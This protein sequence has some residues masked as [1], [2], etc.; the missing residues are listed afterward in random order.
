MRIPVVSRDNQPLMP[1]TPARVRRW[2]A[3]G[4]AIKKWSDLGAVDGLALACSE[5][6]NY[7]SFHIANTRG[8]AW[9]GS[10]QLTPA[11]FRVIRRPPIS[12]RQLHLM[13]PSIGGVRRKYGGTTTRHGVR[14]GDVVKAEMAG[15]VSVG[16]VSGDTQRQ[17]SVSDSNWKRLGQ[18][19]ASKVLLIARNTGLVVSGASLAQPARSA[20]PTQ[21]PLLSLPMPKGRGIS[22]EV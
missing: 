7:E 3:S 20:Y 14:K 6:V 15:R 2:I 4:K 1:T 22:E 17:I 21:P 9:T 12:R 8:H 18:F 16:W 5:F 19:T 10:V 13:V 11:I